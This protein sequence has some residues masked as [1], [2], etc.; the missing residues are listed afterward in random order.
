[1]N[2]L[3]PVILALI[4]F[5]LIAFFKARYRRK[6]A[7]EALR[8]GERPDQACLPQSYHEA[9]AV[10]TPDILRMQLPDPLPM[11]PNSPR[12]EDQPESWQRKMSQHRET[13]LDAWIG[14]VTFVHGTFVGSDPFSLLAK[15]RSSTRWQ[16]QLEAPLAMAV[17]SANDRFAG[18]AGNF[19][20]SWV[21]LFGSATHLPSST[22]IWSSEN[23]HLAR[24]D[25]AVRLAFHLEGRL[26][27][28]A[29]PGRI[30]LVGHSHAGQIFAL[31]LQLVHRVSHADLLLDVARRMGTG[32]HG[33]ER[34]LERLRYV[35][36]NTLTLGTPVRYGWPSG[37]RERL[38]HIVNHRGTNLSAGRLDGALSTRDGDYVQ[39]WGIAGSDLPS[40]GPRQA[41]NAEL[42]RVL[43][44][45][46]A[47]RAWL[48]NL[49]HR[50]RVHDGGNTL[51]VDYRDNEPSGRPNFLTTNFGHAIYTRRQTMEFLVSR[52]VE[53][54][55]P[56]PTGSPLLGSQSPPG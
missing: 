19:E 24:L 39:Q 54:L 15:L 45:G 27:M 28:Q 13:L 22:F 44:L 26:A 32:I 20:A 36:V 34:A 50:R 31:L 42:D 21:H 9:P 23:T 56:A 4:S 46:Y 14:E 35:E 16:A 53:H 52:M 1:M 10:Q 25:A 47:P 55:R 6:V 12:F 18:D 29:T 17:K 51:L 41:L 3:L 37:A 11:D 40:T 8:P 2:W 33:L 48:D 5:G 49:K 43:G 30:Y 7:R 38:L